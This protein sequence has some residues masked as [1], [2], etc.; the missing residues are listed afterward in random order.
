MKELLSRGLLTLISLIA[1]ASLSSIS[2]DAA[3]Y[4][5]AA[6]VYAFYASAVHAASL[7]RHSLLRLAAA[8]RHASPH[9]KFHAQLS[10]RFLS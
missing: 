2:I 3:L 4:A 9:C 10:R 1:R 7:P 8:S 6:A 5:Y